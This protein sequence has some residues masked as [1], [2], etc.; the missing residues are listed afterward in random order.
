MRLLIVFILIIGACA[1]GCSSKRSR[2]VQVPVSAKKTEQKVRRPVKKSQTKRPSKGNAV[3]HLVYPQSVE[4]LLVH[5]SGDSELIRIDT[6]LSDLNLSPGN[7]HIQGVVSEGLEYEALEQESKFDFKIHPKGPSYVGSFFIECPG[8]KKK[9]LS[10]VRK[11]EF[12]HRYKFTSLHGT[13]EM[14]VG[15]DLKRVRRAWSRL[16]KVPASR[17]RLAF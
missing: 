13:C 16:E 5:E 12:F 15:N 11:M 14:V 8:V 7:W 17:L 6:R 9:N 3:W 2:P 10:E 1:S 4:L